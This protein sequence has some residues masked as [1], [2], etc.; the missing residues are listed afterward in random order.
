MS[1]DS[2]LEAINGPSHRLLLLLAELIFSNLDGVLGADL[3]MG[4]IFF[5]TLRGRFA[6]DHVDVGIHVVIVD[7]DDV[8]RRVYQEAC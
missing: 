2:F 1:E 7:V 3:S 4:V 8:S 5:F 6:I